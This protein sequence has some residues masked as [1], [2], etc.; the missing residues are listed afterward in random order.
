MELEKNEYSMEFE[1]P[2]N[3]H[4]SLIHITNDFLPEKS[5]VI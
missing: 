4:F 2:W 1:I 5:L 3:I